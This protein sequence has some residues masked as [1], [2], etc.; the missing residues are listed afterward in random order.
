MTGMGLQPDVQMV[1]SRIESI[2]DMYVAELRSE[3]LTTIAL[4]GS[5]VDAGHKAE[6]N[7]DLDI[8]T[9]FKDLEEASS[10]PTLSTKDFE[11]IVHLNAAIHDKYSDVNINVSSCFRGGPFKPAP[12]KNVNIEV[13]NLIF[14]PT[15]W[16]SEEPT[17]LFDRSRRNRVLWGSDPTQYRRIDNIT[18]DQVLSNHFG[19]HHCADMIRKSVIWYE[20]WKRINPETMVI[21]SYQEPVNINNAKGS[22]RPIAMN[23]YIELI[24]YSIIKCSINL[25]RAVL[26]TI[27]PYAKEIDD[28]V[29]FIDS[30]YASDMLVRILDLK[31]HVRMNTLDYSS[32]DIA[33]L[34]D[35]ALGYLARL[36]SYCDGT[37][38]SGS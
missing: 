23:T 30:F 37:A 28:T 5:F 3:N 10:V 12:I 33:S 11:S 25:K 35:D 4:V 31:K 9:V 26:K 18:I 24:C 27:D 29:D 6:M 2:L 38:A 36:E 7:N 22:A 32:L 21:E 1:T 14:T 19:I 16:R 34:K 17:I 8:L 13:H 15:R 20:E